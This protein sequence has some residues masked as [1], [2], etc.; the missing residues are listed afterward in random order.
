MD[1]GR[2][3]FSHIRTLV[4]VLACL[5]GLAWFLVPGGALAQPHCY[6]P[7]LPPLEDQPA[8]AGPPDAGPIEP[9]AGALR[10]RLSDG[11]DEVAQVRQLFKENVL[12]QTVARLEG[13]K[14]RAAS[15]GEWNRL[16]RHIRKIEKLSPGYLAFVARDMT[17]RLREAKI[18]LTESQYVLFVDRN[19]SMQVAL[20]G[21]Y[22]APRRELVPVGL[23]LISTGNIT[24]GED[25]FLTPLGVFENVVDNFGYR[26]EG[27]PNKDGWLGLGARGSRVWDFGYQRGRKLYRGSDTLSQM[28]LLIHSTDPVGGEQRLGRINSKGCIRIS[29]G[30]NGFL[31]MYSILDKNYEEWA[32]T[33]KKTW[34]LNKDRTP[35][36][37]PGRYLIIGDSSGADLSPSRQAA[38]ERPPSG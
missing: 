28:R 11:L 16:D 18:G 34:L 14:Q 17:E 23:D 7:A 26:A 6:S 32:L 5:A 4:G 3:R 36:R 37:F 12:D 2:K 27:T 33:K 13:Y 10:G 30:L 21:F 20:V 1:S 25:Y 31:D 9:A 19:P 15:K 38:A 35:V 24:H 29:A 22:N 8:L